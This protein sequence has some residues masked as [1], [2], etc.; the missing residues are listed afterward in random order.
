MDLS[1]STSSEEEKKSPVTSPIPDDDAVTESLNDNALNNLMGGIMFGNVGEDGQLENPELAEIAN[2][3]GLKNMNV[4]QAKVSE[5]INDDMESDIDGDDL[6]DDV[7]SSIGADEVD[8]LDMSDSTDADD[9][10]DNKDN[11]IESIDLPELP[12]PISLNKTNNNDMDLSSSSDEE[13][14]KTKEK[15]RRKKQL[16]RGNNKSPD[17][18]TSPETSKLA[19]SPSSIE[20]NDTAE[21][22]QLLLSDSEKSGNDDNKT[23]RK[24][25]DNQKE[26][27]YQLAENETEAQKMME[28]LEEQKNRAKNKTSNPSLKRKATSSHLFAKRLSLEDLR[29]KNW[30]KAFEKEIKKRPVDQIY[31]DFKENRPLPF[32][33]ML[34]R[35]KPTSIYN[36]YKYAKCRDRDNTKL[37]NQYDHIIY[38]PEK[39]LELP[40]KMITH[41][42][43]LPPEQVEKSDYELLI[44]GHFDITA[45]TKTYAENH[46]PKYMDHSSTNNSNNITSK[47]NRFS[48]ENN[49]FRLQNDK[50]ALNG[51]T[52]A[53]PAWRYGPNKLWYDLAGVTPDGKGPDGRPYRLAYAS[54]YKT[55]DGTMSHQ[56]D[57]K[58]EPKD[59][60]S[61]DIG[62]AKILKPSVQTEP[63]SPEEELYPWQ[64]TNWEDDIIWDEDSYKNWTPEQLK[65]QEQRIKLAGWIPTPDNRTMGKKGEDLVKQI[66]MIHKIEEERFDPY[67]THI[68]SQNL[69]FKQTESYNF[70]ES[71]NTADTD[72]S[73]Y[74]LITLA[75]KLNV[76]IPNFGGLQ[77]HNQYNPM[78]GS[79][80]QNVNSYQFQS[81]PY[82][83]YQNGNLYGDQKFGGHNSKSNISEPRHIRELAKKYPKSMLDL[84]DDYE[85]NRSDDWMKQIIWDDTCIT[86]DI[87]PAEFRIDPNDQDLLLYN[88]PEP[89]KTN[90][91]EEANQ[92]PTLKQRKAKTSKRT[93]KIL[94]KIGFYDK[95]VMDDSSS[96]SDDDLANLD[97]WNLSNDVFYDAP[98]RKAHKMD[99]SH[100]ITIQ[101]ALPAVQL[102][103]P[104]IPTY[105]CRNEMRNFHRPTLRHKW[106]PSNNPDPTKFIEQDETWHRRKD[107][108][109]KFQVIPH[110]YISGLERHII[111]VTNKRKAE[112]EATGGGDVFFMRT[113][114]DLSM[115]DGKL[116]HFEYSEEYPPLVSQPGMCTILR[117]YYK[118]PSDDDKWLP[119]AS[120]IGLTT[121]MLPSK[122]I[123]LGTLRDRE[124]MFGLE[125]NMF[126]APC[127]EHNQRETDFLIIRT[128]KGYHIREISHSFA[129]GQLCPLLEVYSPKSKR[130]TEHLREFLE[131]YIYRLFRRTKAR[132]IEKPDLHKIKM[133]DI[134]KAFVTHSE[135]MIRKRLKTCAE[136]QR[137]GAD[138][139]WWILRPN[140]KIM[141]EDEIQ[142]KVSPENCCQNYSMLSAQQHLKDMGFTD[143]TGIYAEIDEDFDA[144]EKQDM[145]NK[146]EIERVNAP[147]NTTKAF[148]LAMDG[149]CL[150]QI[151][152]KADPTGRNMGFSYIRVPN[153]PTSSQIKKMEAK[154]LESGQQRKVLPNFNE[155]DNENTRD[156]DDQQEN[157]LMGDNMDEDKSGDPKHADLRKLPLKTARRICKEF[158]VG[159][160][161]LDELKRWDVIDVVRQIASTMKKEG[162]E[163]EMDSIINY[164][165]GNK[166]SMNEHKQLNQKEAQERFIYQNKQLACYD[167]SS[168]DQDTTT[169][170]DSDD[171]DNEIDDF[172]A[173][174]I[175]DYMK[176]KQPGDEKTEEDREK[177][178][179]VSKMKNDQKEREEEKN[180]K[181]AD[182]RSHIHTRP[183]KME[184]T[185]LMEMPNGQTEEQVQTVTKPE[186]ILFYDRIRETMDLAQIKE[187]LNADPEAREE[188]KKER[189]RIQ[190]QLRRLR[191]HAERT[192][193]E[194]KEGRIAPQPISRNVTL[195]RNL[196][197]SLLPTIGGSNAVFT[198]NSSAD[199]GNLQIRPRQQRIVRPAAHSRAHANYHQHRGVYGQYGPQRMAMINNNNNNNNKKANEN[200]TSIQT[201][202]N[203]IRPQPV[204][205]NPAPHPNPAPASANLRHPPLPQK[206][207]AGPGPPQGHRVTCS[208]CGEVGHMKNS[209]KCKKSEKFIEW[210]R[211]ENEKNREKKKREERQKLKEELKRKEAET[212]LK[213]QELTQSIEANI[214]GVS[215]NSR[216]GSS[217]NEKLSQNGNSRQNFPSLKI[218]LGSKDSAKSSKNS[219]NVAQNN[220]ND[221]QIHLLLV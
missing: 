63:E 213:M 176:N 141:T 11:V 198:G 131:V 59:P 62:I 188:F 199:C 120:D 201:N 95:D 48:R 8:G 12:K 219:S 145:K 116:F 69:N 40:E 115:K 51:D 149:S 6:D 215:S 159:D 23:D 72:I 82:S 197:R 24:M 57:I 43:E 99:T 148:L 56:I 114:Q 167:E 106:D 3:S 78:T 49:D 147:W 13:E 58:S 152:G 117:Y 26:L 190:E 192:A 103:S 93:A 158:G 119:P 142:Q 41:A 104:C 45:L 164:S 153:K 47:Y 212:K 67:A 139:N 156:S 38:K 29:A 73:N 171:E 65:R 15:Q 137:T 191:K 183:C 108:K 97:P 105:L 10:S 35:P 31:P 76:Q 50:N 125:N 174:A 4:G 169:D 98:V 161:E 27:I 75:G 64:I 165:R 60:N 91:G 42:E 122:K 184:I 68:T 85:I 151:T 70:G 52:S 202:S 44:G 110:M 124:T 195:N 221:Q 214:M 54:D 90:D 129:V 178:R 154:H 209:R 84:E 135:S 92:A 1:L 218:K 136:F 102:Q 187:Y 166:Y 128:Q 127:F 177:E 179:L 28:D 17:K 55:T 134:R 77:A 216:E 100:K 170:D 146:E 16:Y 200:N 193:Q 205:Q 113:I 182:G 211:R 130:A 111:D 30:I 181:K 175:D 7:E 5:N 123:F 79:Y 189:R 81:N 107:S 208:T 22:S 96:S 144:D 37:P 143:R 204:Q 14:A 61:H 132:S 25:I 155:K 172:L 118:M 203:T 207:T 74:G 133:E 94:K 217:K 109:I 121:K 185:R 138:S 89:E 39:K 66:E 88:P 196:T 20:E 21:T 210:Q 2:L 86:E 33:K 186:V 19:K 163:S 71:G 53:Y 112:R 220:I 87:H 173:Q 157:D 34:H 168:T 206:S 101:H 9:E 83:N 32:L 150:L 126:R 160:K 18:C 194:A 140:T 46:E 80:D 180:Q 162:R 36:K